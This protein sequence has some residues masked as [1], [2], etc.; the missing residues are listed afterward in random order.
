[1][2]KRTYLLTAALAA[3]VCLLPA[4]SAV[5][6]AQKRAKTDVT[7]NKN[8]YQVGYAHLDTQWRW[9]YVDSIDKYLKNT[10]NDNF[11]L[12]EKYPD[13]VFNFT[14]SRRYQMMKQYYPA[15]Y[16]RMKQYIKQGRWYPC[17]SSVDENDV[18]VPSPEAIIR[19]VLYGNHYFQKEF[20][21]APT[22]YIL[23][24]CFGFPASLPSILAHTGA[25]GFATQK[26]TWG[27]A[28]GIPFPV[29][30]WEGLDGKQV[31][32]ALDAGG[33]G[34]RVTEDLSQSQFL[35]GR[36]NKTGDQSGAYV[37]Y[38]YFGTGD[39]G[40]APTD[41]SVAWIEKSLKG[42]GPVKIISAPAD[43]LFND[44]TGQQVSKLPR[45]KGDLELTQHSAGSITS[46]A[47]M[48]R[49]NRKN[50]LLI[51]SAERASVAADWLG[52]VAY[53]RDKFLQTWYLIL[54]SQMHD[55][56]P[57][58]SIPRAYEFSWN[59]E[60]VA[61]NQSAET[62]T[63]A[64]G[65]ISRGID[66]RA[67]GVPV[68]VYNPLSIARED[69]VEATLRFPG[70]APKAVRVYGATGEVPSQIV[71]RQAGSVAVIFLADV[72]S[73]GVAS[74]DVRPSATPFTGATGLKVSNSS[75][76]NRRYRVTLN[77]EG[78]VAQI[79]DKA[80]GRNMLSAPAQLA[81]KFEEPEQYPAWNM[82]WKDQS[83]PPTGYVT[84]P[85]AVKIIE[86]GPVRVTLEVSRKSQG[87][88]FVQ[89][90]RLA[91][92][93]AGNRVEFDNAIDWNTLKHNIKATFPLA[94]HNDLATY[95]LGFGTIQRATNDP[96]K[97]EVV[98]RHWFDLT[99]KKGDYGVT[100]LEDSK[101]GSD[102][103]D[104]HTL[105]LTLLRTPSTRSYP[106]QATQDIGHHRVL[107]ALEG[108]K[109][110]WRQGQ[111]HWEGA[112]LNQPLMAFQTP[113]HAGALG[114]T[115]SF[116]SANSGRVQ[117][118]AIKKA[119]DSG[120]IVVRVQEVTG[121]P[122]K[123][124]RIHALRPILSAREVNGQEQPV[125]AATVINGDLVTNLAQYGARAFALKVAPA[126]VKLT[127]PQSQSV[128]IPYDIQAASFP[129]KAASNS[130][131]GAGHTIAADLLP[132]TIVSE[133]VSFKMGPAGGKSAL[134][135][136]GQSIRLP[137]GSYNEVIV[138][139][140]A[141]YGDQIGAF[142]VDGRPVTLKVQDWSGFIGQWDDRI[143][144]PEDAHGAR[145]L[146]G[147]IYGLRPAF[148]KRDAL[149]WVGEHRHNADG[150][151][152]TYAYSYLYKYSI[153]VASGAKALKLPNNPNIRVFAVTAAVNPNGDT[154]PVQYLYDAF[155]APAAPPAISPVAGVYNNSVEV[156]LRPALYIDG[157]T[158]RY[159]TDG[160][161]PTATSEAYAAPILVASS[162][163]V[164][165]AAFDASGAS[166]P[167]ASAKFE[168][169][170]TT[171]PSV[172]NVAAMAGSSTVRVSFTEP[173]DRAAAESAADYSIAGITVRSARRNSDGRAVDLTVEPA[174]TEGASYTLTMAGLKD[175]SPAGNGLS[176]TRVA[177]ET[178]APLYRLALNKDILAGDGTDAS[179]AV[180]VSGEPSVVSGPTGAALAFTGSEG[181]TVADAPG[182]DP[183]NALT[184]SVW[185]RPESWDKNPPVLQKGRGNSQYALFSEDGHL[186]F[187]LEGVGEVRSAL[188]S[189][190]E[191]HN[192]AAT[193]D[194]A[195]LKL[196]VDGAEASSTEVS[197]VV[198]MTKD[199]LNIATRGFRGQGSRT[200][201][202]VQPRPAG[203]AVVSTVAYTPPPLYRAPAGFVGQIS[204]VRIYDQALLPEHV[205]ALANAAGTR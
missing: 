118:T 138:L 113:S 178:A 106:D 64:V 35:L 56:L 8:S 7:Q 4:R 29:G 119:E 125:G 47:Y 109:G 3:G 40:G 66:T 161:A 198:P 200:A 114:K 18:N 179:A 77:S 116:F 147:N 163:E 88:T 157:S 189:L 203:T 183:S 194:G 204:D 14:G 93:G 175:C 205:R 76:E 16:A 30:V 123:G 44:L 26:L 89:H 128:A 27:S 160:S 20:G 50:E 152:D 111:S 34:A 11:A 202:A 132:T 115:F 21:F 37:D 108:H 142:Q 39:V 53:P 75:V 10:L 182:M 1:M 159:T 134:T 13:Y 95:N 105:R 188:P 90:I 143:F 140:A 151:N 46:Q 131:D 42:A 61:L 136:R 177:F 60:V 100:V 201:R 146:E 153:P 191:W 70:G 15:E 166:G 167:V 129:G 162:T 36:I 83:A 169:K 144:S 195:S 38:R 49:W 196:Y 41:E 135:A 28:A 141:V 102:K 57:G 199:A 84:G 71:K 174:L 130:F 112:R 103:P 149:A 54:G 120:E 55:I 139:A 51:D 91:A 72:P 63:S 69:V 168:V 45:Y 79:F 85:A 171:A 193:Y 98:S 52:G 117:I 187:H 32:A 101:F 184:V 124:V 92:N 43:Q 156:A 185:V 33:Y 122:I 65:A 74:Y 145:L 78:D 150:S 2:T 67:K 19:N 6:A 25:K 192:I 137:K 181:V 186:A 176:Q 107:Y 82:D 190:N 155:T 23:P 5:P 9:S 12:F 58:T 127:A 68:V 104:D 110:D 99:D 73:V 48:K 80:A 62:L 172:A 86:N 94:V 170:D 121:S 31:I 96:K 24:D 59:D 97:Y 87:S 81:F 22:D 148:I 197:G 173:M 158:L 164:K 180:R 126:P 17:G 165:V 154:R 133:G